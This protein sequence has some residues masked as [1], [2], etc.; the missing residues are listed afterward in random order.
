MVG[1]A[2]PSTR[3]FGSTDPNWSEIADFEQIIAR[4]ASAVTP[5]GAQ[6]RKTAV[7]PLKSH[8]S[9]RKSATKFLCEKTV[10]GKVV[11]HSLA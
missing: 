7:F 6:K 9:R 2:T 4:N 10:S 8:F 1:G 11:G 3:N 5:K